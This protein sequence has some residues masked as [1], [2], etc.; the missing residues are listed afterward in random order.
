MSE[1]EGGLCV[2]IVTARH[3]DGSGAKIIGCFEREIDAKKIFDASV[4]MGA[5]MDV[6]VISMPLNLIAAVDL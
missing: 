5:C 1:Q 6:K 3:W 4:S 2:Y